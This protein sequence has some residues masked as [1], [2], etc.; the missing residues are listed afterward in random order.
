MNQKTCP[1]CGG[2]SYS[3]YIGL[4][5]ICPY[6]GKDL[7]SLPN[8]L[9][10]YSENYRKERKNSPKLYTIQGGKKSTFKL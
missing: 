8:D 9:H 1:E 5:W 6:C 2:R 4:E 10:N 7:G 3:S